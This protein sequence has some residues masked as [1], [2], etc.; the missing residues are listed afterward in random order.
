MSILDKLFG[1]PIQRQAKQ[2]IRNARVNTVRKR[3]PLN[4]I[5]M[6]VI[7]GANTCYQSIKPMIIAGDEER[8]TYAEF[9]VLSEFVFFFLHMVNRAAHPLFTAA[10]FEK[11]HAYCGEMVIPVVID[12]FMGHWPEEMKAKIRGEFFE[13][14]NKA[15]IEYSKAT[16]LFS[17]DQPFLGDSLLSMLARAIAKRCGQPTN[18]EVMMS[19]MDSAMN[20]ITDAKFEELISDAARVL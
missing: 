9:S 11:L 6:A 3:T 13:N 19:V 14:L 20:A 15:E 12:S 17:K 2:I 5:G 1:T 4:K 10:Q 7:H 18:P 16:A 8:T